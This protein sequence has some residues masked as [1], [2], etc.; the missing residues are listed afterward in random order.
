MLEA[1]KE[2][3]IG[4]SVKR[5]DYLYDTPH[6]I[7]LALVAI[8]TI[9]MVLIF[10]KKSEKTKRIVLWVFF[11]IFLTFEILARVMGIIKGGDIAKT[12][13]PM[14]FCSIMV[15]FIIIS[16]AFNKKSLYSISAI[17]GLLATTAYLVYPAVGLNVEVINFSAFYSIFSHSLGF[18]ISVWLLACGFTSYKFKDI[19]TSLTF[20]GVVLI[21]SAILNFVIYPGE[22]YMYYVENPFPFEIGAWFQVLYALVIITYISSFYVIYYLVR[23]HRAKKS[24]NKNISNEE[25]ATETS[26]TNN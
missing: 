19:W 5:T 8:T 17:G 2:F 20:T 22:N 14:H 3:F 18:V 11:G 25:I 12:I 4:S 9:A 10:R 26:N 23:K 21:Y 1:I 15:W 6:L 7:T 24:L 13:L 16:I